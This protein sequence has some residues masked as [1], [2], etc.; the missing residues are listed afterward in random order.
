MN[1]R[2]R[3]GA[4]LD[5]AANSA[6]SHFRAAE[7]VG[8]GDPAVRAARES[9]LGALLTA[10]DNELSAKRATASRR[11]VDACGHAEQLRART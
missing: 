10:A 4:L 2:L 3:R 11:L 7:Q 9:L 1:E 5:P 8:P 6:V